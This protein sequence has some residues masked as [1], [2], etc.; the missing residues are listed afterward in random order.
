VAEPFKLPRIKVCGVRTAA[1]VL[2]VASAGGDAI[3]LVQHRPSPRH[4][5]P[6][7]AAA[8][9]AT[10]PVGLSAILVVVDAQADPLER[11]ARDAGVSAVQLCGGERASDWAAF[12]LP[13]LRRI[14]VQPG[15]ERELEQW[16]GIATG[17][18]LDHPAG[19][20]G[21]GHPVDLE[22]A[23]RLAARAPCL[24]A[25]G[26]DAANVAAL[27]E[28]VRPAGVDASSRLESARGVKDPA[29]IAA[30]VRAARAALA[31]VPA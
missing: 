19:P 10:L 14:P 17:F 27:I 30:F 5:E 18:V 11:S 12:P 4:L 20:G 22:L 31:E 28:R 6:H 25:G 13:V 3:G 15:A 7:E 26:L 29:R 24:L 2:A 16:L 21:T 23:A 8:L 9:V 1:D